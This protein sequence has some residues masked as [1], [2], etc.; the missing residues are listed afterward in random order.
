MNPSPSNHQAACASHGRTMT[1]QL[2]VFVALVA[3]SLLLIA[4]PAAHAATEV[5]ID[6]LNTD[7]LSILGDSIGTQKDG[8]T[9]SNTVDGGLRIEADLDHYEPLAYTEGPTGCSDE[10]SDP[11]HP[12]EVN[13]VVCDAATT[14]TLTFGL[15]ISLFDGDDYLNTAGLTAVGSF[16]PENSNIEHDNE[17]AARVELMGG[18]DTFI[19]GPLSE[20]VEDGLGADYVSSGAGLDFLQQPTDTTNPAADDNGDTLDAGTGQDSRVSYFGT[21]VGVSVTLDGAAND[22]APGEQ[23]NVAPQTGRVDGTDFADTLTGNSFGQ[24]LEGADGNDVVDGMGGDDLVVGNEGDDTLTG[25]TGSDGASGDEGD[26]IINLADGEDDHFS[27]DGDGGNDGNDVVNVD[28]YP[29][30]AYSE[31]VCETVNRP[32]SEDQPADPEPEPVAP[33]P[34]A[35]APVA[36]A[37]QVAPTPVTPTVAPPLG[38]TVPAGA[39]VATD[40]TGAVKF[41][42]SCGTTKCA[43]KKLTLNAKV[44]GKTLKMTVTVPALAAG[45]QASV[46]LKLSKALAKAV[47]KAGKRGVKVTIAGP[48]GKPV[49]L[50]LVK[51]H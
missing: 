24:V 10:S 38:L 50:T 7:T 30:D 6:P 51:K 17:Y 16:T 36:P 9:V 43:A 39:K 35:P 15:S 33:A 31:G 5:S 32:A 45:K 29:F 25:G 37:P 18:D 47:A 41:A 28:A 12:L 19:G 13:A 42:F 11:D 26:D 40:S 1:N 44:G 20:R 27:C 3:A 49:T 48:T 8:I 46:K 4:V 34:V 2:R 14:A 22:G 21:A 23:D